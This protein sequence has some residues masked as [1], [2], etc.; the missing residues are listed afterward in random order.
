MVLCHAMP[1][2]A[3]ILLR[4]DAVLLDSLDDKLHDVTIVPLIL[5]PVRFM[6]GILR[7][8]CHVISPWVSLYPPA[9]A[10]TGGINK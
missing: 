8:V 3:L 6:R 7:V 4:E 5:A 2:G 10:Q 1:V 9:W